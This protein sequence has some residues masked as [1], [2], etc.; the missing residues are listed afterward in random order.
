MKILQQF[1]TSMQFDKNIVGLVN[2]KVEIKNTT[3]IELVILNISME[4]I[5][6]Y[7]V[8]I[9]ILFLLCL[10]DIN[11]LKVFFNNIINWIIQF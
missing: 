8:P 4:I 11:K 9:N 1:N 6:F 5:I 10:A 7:I 2:F 3:S